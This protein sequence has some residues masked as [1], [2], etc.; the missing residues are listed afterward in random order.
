MTNKQTNQVESAKTE[1][2]K[3]P[4]QINEALMKQIE[5]LSKKITE[6]ES[7]K[8]EQNKELKIVREALPP[9]ES[10]KLKVTNY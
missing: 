2:N 8:T 1:Q 9:L 10:I 7:A 4:E 3:T 6:L 5:T